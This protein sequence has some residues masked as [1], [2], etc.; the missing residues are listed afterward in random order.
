MYRQ[1]TAIRLFEEQVVDNLYTR[2]LMQGLAHLYIGQEAVAVGVCEALHTD[3]YITSTAP[4]PR[5][6][7]G[8]GRRSRG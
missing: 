6:L 7:P 8:E 3:D 2:A 4:G 1:M 5:P